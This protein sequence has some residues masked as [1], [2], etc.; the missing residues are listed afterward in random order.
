MTKSQLLAVGSTAELDGTGEARQLLAR[1]RMLIGQRAQ[2]KFE[3][4]EIDRRLSELC[5]HDWKWHQIAGEGRY[6]TKCGKRDFDC[7][8]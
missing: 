7:D 6:C 5:H 4:S 2:A 1:R 8:D 3:I